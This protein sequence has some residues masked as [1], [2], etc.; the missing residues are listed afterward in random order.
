MIANSH[1]DPV[2]HWQWMEGYATVHATFR[3]VVDLLRENRDF[4]FVRGCAQSY[5]WVEEADRGLFCEIRRLVRDGRWVIVNGW[6]E[7]PDC[8]MPSGESFARQA[9]YAQRYFK[10]KFGVTASVGYNVDSFGHNVGL[11][12]LLREAGMHAYVFMRPGPGEIERPLPAEVFWWKGA[13]GSRV[14][15]ARIPFT[16]SFEGE[17]EEFRRHVRQCRDAYPPA[18]GHS[19]CF[20]GVGNH[21]G[22]PSRR[23]IECIRRLNADPNEPSVVFSHPRRFFDA[24]RRGAKDLPVVRGELQYHSPGCFSAQSEVKRLHRRAEYAV[25]RAEKLAAMGWA[26]AGQ[27]YR[28]DE[29]ERAWQRILFNE[30]HDTLPGTGLMEAYEDAKAELYEAMAIA[31][32]QQNAGVHAIARDVDTSGDGPAV[33]LFN[34]HGS[35]VKEPV[36]VQFN[37]MPRGQ[38]V[39]AEGRP[40]PFQFIRPT[41]LLRDGRIVFEADVPAMGWHC[42]TFDWQGMP[43]QVDGAR[44]DGNVLENRWWRIEVD[45]STGEFV[46]LLDKAV[47]REV[48]SAAGNCAQVVE[49]RFDTWGHGMGAFDRVQGAFGR[50][51]LSVLERGPVRAT[52][53]IERRYGRSVLRQDVSVYNE[54]PRIDLRCFVDWCEQWKSLKLAFSVN[55]TEPRARFEQAYAFVERPTDGHE[56]VMQRW[57]DVSG[58]DEALGQK[59]GL[60]IMNDGKYGCDVRG[61]VVRITAL[62]GCPYCWHHPHQPRR[63]ERYYFMD[64]GPQGFML[65]LWPHAGDG[66]PSKAILSAAVLNEPLFYEFQYPKTGS[67]PKVFSYLR[68][69]PQNVVVAAMKRAEDTN[70]LVMRLHETA[71]RATRAVVRFADGSSL[72]R[73]LHG[74]QVITLQCDPSGRKAR[75]V[76]FIEAPARHS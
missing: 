7:Q 72:V 3:A 67:R 26:L 8:N 25:I 75:R 17:L 50:A 71:G 5:A 16:Y 10:R 33:L 15:T 19:L 20:Y 30:H 31:G 14:L 32:R 62:R 54:T 2:W 59:F 70:D 18:L 41:T 68:V 9:L 38:L 66:P 65:A 43:P 37:F 11:P 61:H 34:A 63:G 48:L 51:R 55:A 44:V 36:E 52:L 76:N 69:E 12:Q 4:V 49:D 53:R 21:G 58:R 39:D 42:Y 60:T 45:E 24:I 29:F 47:G 40:V 73:K 35:R 28:C 56:T 23:A 1:I 46:R 64:Q 57:V 74:G 22:G 6:W 27:P 13:D